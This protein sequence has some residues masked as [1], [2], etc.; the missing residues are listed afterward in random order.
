M[1]RSILCNYV[2]MVIGGLVGFLLTPLLIHGLGDYYYGMWVLAA[3]IVDYYGLADIGIRFTL[4]RHVARCKG[5]NERAA[6][7]RTV[8]TALAISLG[9]A[10][11]ILIVT[12]AL[13]KWLP[14]A[15]RVSGGDRGVF[16]NVLLLLGISFAVALPGKV[17]GAYLCGL[18]RFDLYNLIGSSTTIV[19]A[20]LIVWALQRGYGIE[21][22]ATITLITAVV[23]LFLQ[24]GMIQVADPE[25]SLDL[26]NTSWH[27]LRWLLSFGS[28]VFISQIGDVF[29]YRLDS[30]VIASRL[31]IALVTHFNI[32]AKVV[33]YFRYLHSGIIGPLITEMSGLEG[34]SKE[35]AFQR[36]F[37]KSTRITVLLSLLV[38]ALLCI[39]GRALFYLWVG[40]AYMSSYAVLV[41]LVIGRTVQTMQSPSM[42][43]LLA[44][45]R[46]KALGW[47]TLAEGLL[48]LTLSIYWV[49]KYGILG[50]ALGTTVPMLLFRLVVQ[51][52]YTLWVARI[53][54]VRYFAE[55][56]ARP[57]LVLV[58]FLVSLRF[59]SP[60]LEHPTVASLLAIV[61]CQ[62][63]VYGVLAYLI[64]LTGLER[65]GLFG[66]VRTHVFSRQAVPTV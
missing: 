6:L 12:F 60:S 45:G 62:C 25:A 66:L 56:L 26:R 31:N 32:A 59:V 10:I 21:G 65:Q 51:P 16:V 2:G 22:C 39:D 27:E 47:W 15:F 23:S 54:P 4:Q 37:L 19:Q 42:V 57:A 5:A 64:G 63:T 61:F 13:A 17:L 30:L 1:I 41:T 52:W 43:V 58:T 44:R 46:H 34:G 14:L 49:G 53:S 7:D 48:N 40:N 8:V 36:L 28:Y 38:A 18:Q 55:S 11:I 9:V 35:E 29:R 20:I 24:W 33:E 3:S 50:V